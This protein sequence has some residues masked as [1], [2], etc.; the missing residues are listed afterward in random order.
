MNTE[1]SPLE[2]LKSWIRNSVMLKLVTITILMLLL[3]IPTA[4][5]QSI[6]H[7]RESLSQQATEEV[8]AKWAK[9]QQINGP[10]F[11]I[12]YMEEVVEEGKVTERRRYLSVLPEV[13]SIRGQVEPRTLKRGIYEVVVYESQLDLSGSFDLKKYVSAK[14][15]PR[16]LYDQAFLTIGISDLRGIVEQVFLKWNGEELAVEPGSRLEG[17]IASG[18]T[19]NLPDV[20]EDLEQSVSFD[21]RLDLQGSKQLS[22]IPLG[23]VTQVQLASG[24]PAPSFRGNFLPDQREVSQA[25][26]E[27]SWKILQLNRNFPQSWT[28]LGPRTELPKAEFGAEFLLP[29]D[30]YQK[31]M[32]SAK[33]G[34]MTIALTFL[35][36]FLIEIISKRKIHPFQYILVGLALCIFYVLLV[37]ISEHTQFNLAY[38]IS[39]AAV[40]SMIGLYS[41][42]VFKARRQSLLLVVAL[43][44]IY[45][46]MY[47]TLQLTDYALLMGAVG[48][49]LTLA[50][51]MYFTRNINWYQLNMKSE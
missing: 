6:I 26:F 49:T 29:L 4:M 1:Q 28:D 47:I 15:Y 27:A 45:G 17:L 13:L 20:Y 44:G 18:I 31:S 34:V 51:S 2:S 3:L 19:V 37:S 36:F 24:W 5:I 25:G 23:S 10:I 39:T 40:V 48:L 12:P 50:A 43:L 7:E 42:S 9:A 21:F 8:S 16:L 22:F 33:Y 46:F 11:T 38:F 35:I 32:R 30:D 14:K 41:L